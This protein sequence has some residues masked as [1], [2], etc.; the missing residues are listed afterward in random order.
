MRREAWMRSERRASHMG[1]SHRDER[2]YVRAPEMPPRAVS[3][4]D[5]EGEPIGTYL[6][7]ARRGRLRC[8]D[9][10][11]QEARRR[12]VAGLAACPSGR[13]VGRALER[14]RAISHAASQMMGG[15]MP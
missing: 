5:A 13:A 14:A 1:E 6:R 15:R 10:R 11:C 9:M 12:S 7:R 3:R 2:P 4:H 8:T